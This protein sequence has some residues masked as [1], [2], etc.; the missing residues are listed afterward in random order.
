MNGEG[1]DLG[2]KLQE[3]KTSTQ[4]LSTELRGHVLSQNSFIRA[5]HNSF[6][7]RMDHLNADLWLQ[8]ESSE[9]KAIKKKR[10]APTKKTKKKKKVDTDSGFH[11]VA[12]V[13]TVGQV[14]ELDGLKAKPIRLGMFRTLMSFPF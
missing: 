2:D 8:N 13:P 5:I 3:F 11:F 4:A 7:R 14:W 10:R 1:V 6:T 9:A 12:Y